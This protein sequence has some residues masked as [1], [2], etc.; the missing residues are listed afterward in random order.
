MSRLEN[1][2]LWQETSLSHSRQRLSLTRS[3][4]NRASLFRQYE[5]YSTT[6]Q[7]LILDNKKLPLHD[8][9]EFVSG[10]TAQINR[11]NVNE[12]DQEV[13]I[14]NDPNIPDGIYLI[15]YN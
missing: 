5:R 11:I 2:L 1:L 10:N 6:P 13:F 15:K 12:P 4:K 14:E 3:R 8:D 9:G 7:Y